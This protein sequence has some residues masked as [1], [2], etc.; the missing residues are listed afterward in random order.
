MKKEKHTAGTLITT[1]QGKILFL[2]R[3]KKEKYGPKTWGLAAGGVD[4]GLSPRKAAVKEIEEET[5]LE[6]QEEELEAI[7]TFEWEL[8]DLLVHFHAFKLKVTEEFTPKLN[9]EEHTNYCWAK[10][11]EMLAKENLIHGLRE[12]LNENIQED[13]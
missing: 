6:V 3:S 4:E 12:L 7:K 11:Q 13:K 1:T 8:P 2:Y 9:P 10:P 5:G